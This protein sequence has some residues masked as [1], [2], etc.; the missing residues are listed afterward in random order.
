MGRA[1]QTTKIKG[2][3]VRP[4]QVA[5]LVKRHK[6]IVKARVVVKRDRD[7]DRMVVK[8]E[9]LDKM[10]LGYTD[11]IQNIFRIN[12]DVEVYAEGEL[13]IDGLVIEDL[14]KYE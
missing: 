11:S 8:L 12:G 5:E 13:P 4:E 9:S 6:E 3:F 7:Q 1:D 10:N 2:M 14:R